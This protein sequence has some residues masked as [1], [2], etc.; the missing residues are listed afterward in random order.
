MRDEWYVA[1]RGQ[2]GSK[3]YG[4][5]PL[6]QLRELVDTSRV[7]PGDLVWREGMGEWQ[8]AD[9]CEALFPPAPPRRE[10]RDDRRDYDYDRAPRGRG[11]DDDDRPYPRRRYQQQQSSG[12]V[13]PLVVA[14]V[15]VTLCFLTCGGLAGMGM[16][17]SRSSS[18]TCQ[19]YY[20]TPVSEPVDDPPQWQDPNPWQ[21]NP[22]FQDPPFVP[23]PNPPIFQPPDPPIFAPDPN[24][25]FVPDPDGKP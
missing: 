16:L 19:P 11:R 13:A 21:P 12:G 6:Q 18:S 10:P 15:V 24:P 9:K 5:V 1:R 3:R 7:Q 23:D 22:G 14:G 25:I 2:D 17:N 4:P 20:P 8:R